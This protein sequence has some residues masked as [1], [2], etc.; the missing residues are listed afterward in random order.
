MIHELFAYITVKDAAAAVKFYCD[1]FGGEELFRLVEPSGR[2]GHAEVK[3]GPATLMIS[4]E[5]PEYGL[6]GPQALGGTPVSLHI[7]VDDAD[8]LIEKAVA[9]GAKLEREPADK[10][11]GERSGSVVD[12]WGHRWLIGHSIEKVTPEEMQRRYDVMFKE[13]LKQS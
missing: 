3:L 1:V 9:A 13:D 11:Y 2:V 7:H 4:D 12:P 10:F 5:Y 6:R 8:A